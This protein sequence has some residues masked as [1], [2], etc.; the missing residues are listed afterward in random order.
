MDL[1]DIA[2]LTNLVKGISNDDCEN[3]ECSKPCYHQFFET[4]KSRASL[5]KID[6]GIIF[7]TSYTANHVSPTFHS[8]SKAKPTAHSS[9][10]L[11]FCLSSSWKSM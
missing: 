1:T 7:E 9:M 5:T 6:G 2:S 4:W 10:D 3:R 8:N 11:F